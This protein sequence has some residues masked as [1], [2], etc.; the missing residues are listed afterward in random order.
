MK[1]FHIV[2]L[3]LCFTVL[4][5]HIEPLAARTT[6]ATDTLLFQIGVSLMLTENYMEAESC[7]AE[8]VNSGARE[9]AL[10]N[11]R[12]VNLAMW[13]LSLLKSDEA[14]GTIKY[15]F[16]FEA[17][18]DLN[19]KGNT[20]EEA[21]RIDMI[22]RA[23]EMAA[24]QFEQAISREP[25]YA[26]SYLN[27]ASAQAILARWQ[28]KP[29]LLRNAYQNVTVAEQ[30][31]A[32]SSST[33][34]FSLIVKGIIYD[35]MDNPDKRDELFRLAEQQYEV[36][37]DARL[38]ALAERNKAVAAGAPIVFASNKGEKFNVMEDS[39]EVID[40][41][42]LPQLIRSPN[43]EIDAEITSAGGATLYRKDFPQSSLYV[44][45]KDESR[46][47]FF[48]RTGK[49]YTGAAGKGVRIG[50]N[51]AYVMERYGTPLRVQPALGG[52]FLLYQK[53]RLLFFVSNDGTV[54]SWTAWEEKG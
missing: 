24:A 26:G 53:A 50:D 17:A 9:A 11:N 29:T 8:L 51:E 35:Y 22:T 27:M 14:Y 4:L 34:G 33:K 20:E 6:E 47:L 41:I 31:A 3:T 1:P 12:G 44:Y 43:L 13:G 19:T 45:F 23:F 38:G 46:Y 15:V 7:F 30:K 28:D 39:P 40:G 18:P 37:P 32:A 5:G 36:H 49:G 16:P 52:K 2:N 42:S 21:L 54:Q 25:D 10:F 48:Q